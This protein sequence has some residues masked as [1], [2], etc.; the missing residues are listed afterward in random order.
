MDSNEFVFG[1][2]NTM[3]EVPPGTE[4]II[5]FNDE[6]K[7]T[8]TEWGDKISFP[9]TLYSHDSYSNIGDETLTMEWVSKSGC[10]KQLFDALAKSEKS[11]MGKEL[12][13]HYEESK[14]QL[15]RFDTGVYFITVLKD[16]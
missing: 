1:V 5:S 3:R 11:E 10:A 13:K 15:T 2:N 14:W 4:A 8:E 12:K 6:P 9:I 16:D 7:V